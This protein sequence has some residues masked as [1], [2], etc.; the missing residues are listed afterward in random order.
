MYVCRERGIDRDIN[1]ILEFLL[2]EFEIERGKWIYVDIDN[3]WHCVK[4]D[5]TLYFS[6][7]LFF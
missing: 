6:V 3:N 1:K 4:T 2:I 7:K 5:N